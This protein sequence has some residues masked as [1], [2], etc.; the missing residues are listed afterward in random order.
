MKILG[1]TD[2]SVLVEVSPTE[3]KQMIDAE[4][5]D[6]KSMQVRGYGGWVDAVGREYKLTDVYDRVQ[7]LNA[8][9]D[10]LSKVRRMLRSIADVLEPLDVEVK[11]PEEE[12]ED[13]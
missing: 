2:R 1:K 6:L 11:K 5:V 4:D 10:E 9:G 3:L 8:A 13:E 12:T 7:H